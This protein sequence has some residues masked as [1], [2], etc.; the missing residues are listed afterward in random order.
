MILAWMLGFVVV[1]SIGR[2][3]AMV[4]VA[5][6]VRDWGSSHCCSSPTTRAGGLPDTLEC[7][8]TSAPHRDP[9]RAL[10][11]GDDDTTVELQ[12]RL[13]PFTGHTWWQAGMA[14]TYFS[15]FVV[16][17]VITGAVAVEPGAVAHLDRALR[18]R[19][20]DR[21]RR[22][23]AHAHLAALDGQPRRLHRTGRTGGEPGLAVLRHHLG[24][25]GDSQGGRVLQCDRRVPFAACGHPGARARLLLAPLEPVRA[26]CFVAYPLAM[27]FTLVVGGE[28][29]VTDVLAG[30]AVVALSALL[31]SRLE[32]V[33][34]VRAR[35]FAG[36]VDQPSVGGGLR[37]ARLATAGRGGHRDL[38][39]CHDTVAPWPTPDGFRIISV[40]DHVV[41]PP[42]VWQDRLPAKYRG[43]RP[44]S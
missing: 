3:S 13:G 29:Y 24:R 39:V 19:H 27:G 41:E 25:D 43:R 8:C 38:T 28:H 42:G 21:S 30:W 5:R 17:H 40:D 35:M 34:M 2:G 22:V 31:W 4:D 26:C 11:P 18:H 33:P 32:Q 20:R 9:D 6:A 1:V 44:S 10:F 36:P 12:E 37:A 16:P 7:R 23:R 15:F 14:V